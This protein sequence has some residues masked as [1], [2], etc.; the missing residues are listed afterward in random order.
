[1]HDELAADTLQHEVTILGVNT[2]GAESGVPDMCLGRDIPLLQDTAAAKVWESWHVT[3]RDV[4]VLDPDNHVITVY[5]LTEHDLS[6]PD[7]Y[8]TLKGI[9]RDAAGVGP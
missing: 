3:Y 8:A 7:N 2:I 4:F 9:L 6:N 5:N 1:M